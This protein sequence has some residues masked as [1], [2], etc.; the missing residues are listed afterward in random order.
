M[1]RKPFKSSSLGALYS[2]SGQAN[3]EAVHL[4]TQTLVFNPVGGL[5]R[6][7]LVFRKERSLTNHVFLLFHQDK[8]INCVDALAHP[9]LE[10][11]CLRYHSCMCK[12]CVS[13]NGKRK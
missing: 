2:L 8:R 10:E 13:E 9:Y 7:L 5:V 6:Y 11:G 3:H 1:L 12:C 4:L